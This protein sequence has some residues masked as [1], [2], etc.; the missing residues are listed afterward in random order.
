MEQK[1]RKNT[2]GKTKVFNVTALPPTKPRMW[3]N[4]GQLSP[5]KMMM[6][7]TIVRASTRFHP[8]S[9]RNIMIF[10]NDEPSQRRFQY[11]W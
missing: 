3:P 1:R 10:L 4:L 6:M 5:V 11:T 7:L 9:A 8:N 2:E